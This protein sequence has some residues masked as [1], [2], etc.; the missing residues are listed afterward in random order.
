[1]HSNNNPK[2]RACPVLPYQSVGHLTLCFLEDGRVD[3]YPDIPLSNNHELAG[4]F[5]KLCQMFTDH[6]ELALHAFGCCQERN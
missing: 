3:F 5:L 6:P 4:H 2:E 1:M